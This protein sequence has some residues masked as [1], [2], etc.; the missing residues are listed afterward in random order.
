MHV[1]MYVC[2]YALQLSDYSSSLLYWRLARLFGKG[3]Y[4]CT[5]YGVLYVCMYVCMYLK[6]MYVQYLK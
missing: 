2:M 5:M 3:M 1:C 4:V 6:C